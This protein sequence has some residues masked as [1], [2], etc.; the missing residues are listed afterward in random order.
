M[1]NVLR[2]AHLLLVEL[3]ILAQAGRGVAGSLTEAT[4][5]S[6]SLVIQVMAFLASIACWLAG[7]G[8]CTIVTRE[9]H[10]RGSAVVNAASAYFLHASLVHG[11]SV[12]LWLE[13][14]AVH[15]DLDILTPS[16]NADAWLARRQLTLLSVFGV[17]LLVT[18]ALHEMRTRVRID[19]RCKHTRL[20]NVA[21]E[22]VD[23]DFSPESSAS[24]AQ[25]F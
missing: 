2:G 6:L 11:L 21:G 14:F 17:V 13:F 1:H 16:I 12:A 8:C 3:P 9:E 22:T 19:A 24:D 7:V 5:A 20:L 10:V 15:G 23:G 18:F 25:G 4:D